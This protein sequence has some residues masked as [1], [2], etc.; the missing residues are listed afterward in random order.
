MT[1]I[2]LVDDSL[3]LRDL[4]ASFLTDEGFDVTACDRA[5]EA[6]TRLTLWLPDLLILDGRLSGMSGWECLDRVRGAERTARL[7]VLLL[8]AALDDLEQLARPPDDCTTYLAKPFDI[9]ELLTAIHGVI[10]TCNQQ[11]V[12]V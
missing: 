3:E 10:E 5:E 4:V 7:P 2:L 8:S 11:P 12:A 6:L 9:D 1:L